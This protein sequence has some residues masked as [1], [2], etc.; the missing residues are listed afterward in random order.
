MSESNKT[1]TLDS[2][3][4]KLLND[5]KTKDFTFEQ[6]QNFYNNITKST[7]VSDI[8]KE[9]LTSILEDLIKE[10]FPKKSTSIFGPKGQE[11][12][13]LLEEVYS[14]LSNEFDWTHNNV[15]SGV[16]VGGAMLAG[17][18]YVSYFIS[19]KNNDNINIG[20]IYRQ[21]TEKQ[22]P[23][24]EISYRKVSSKEMN[25]VKIIKFSLHEKSEALTLYKE[26]LLEYI[27]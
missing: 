23:F 9:K 24:L 22:D 26:Y 5:F 1:S 3:V 18:N 4:K 2:K 25:E 15:L 7:E 27:Q 8:D 17:R 13:I 21:L 19:Y 20:F 12:K 16:K 6:L 11:A 10:K 14:E